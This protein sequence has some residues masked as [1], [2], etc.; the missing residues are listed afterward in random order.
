MQKELSVAF[1]WHFHQPNYQTQP[2]GIRLMPWARLHAIKDYLDMVLILDKFPNIKLNF[3]IGA[4]LIDAIE[5]YSKEG[6]DIH[7]KLA[8]TPVEELTDDDKLY[9]LNYFFDAN[10]ETLISKNPRYN[11]LYI[12][13]YS[14]AEIGIENFS[15]EEYSDIMMLFNLVWFDPSWKEVYPELKKFEKKGRNYTLKDRQDLINLNRKI[16]KQIIPTFKKYQDDKRI[17]IITSPYNH[18][19]APILINPNDLKTPALKYAMPDCKI[20]LMIDIKEQIKLAIE[21]I[22]KTFGRKPKGFWPSEHC[23]SQ[24]TLDVVANLGFEW[25][26]SDE[27]VLSNSLKKEFIR[28]FRG[29]YE[30]PYDVCSLYLYK[31]KREKEINLVFR[32]S[33]IPNLI[34][35]EYAHH[36]STLCA[37]DLFDR[38]KT[39]Y[40]K[41]KNSPDKKHLF[42]IAMDGENNWDSYEQDGAIFLERIYS[43]INNDKAIKTVLIS[44]YIEKN[45][46]TEKLLKKVTSGSWVNQ[47]FQ[48]WIAEPTKNLAWKYLVQTRNDLKEAENSGRLSK[49]QIKNAKDEI[50]IAEGSDWFWWYGEPNNSGQDHIFD[51]MFR[52]HLKNVYNII[53][54]PIPSYLEMPLISFMGKPLKNPKRNIT[55]L[56]N[57]MVKDND[58]WL[59]AGCI[60][61]PD[62]PVI[63]ENKLIDRIYF[64]TDKDNLY[65]RFDINKYLMS[66]KE[67]FKEYFSIY[68]YIKTYN[69]EESLASPTRTTNK[70]DSLLPVLLDGYNHEVKFALTS[71]RK[72]PLQYSRAVKDGLW[73]L[74]WGHH[75][76]YEHKEIFEVC[77][78]FEDL[79]I[80]RNEN[81]DFFVITGCSG[82]TEEIYPKDIPLSLTRP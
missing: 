20:A 50:Y 34:N 4:E 49:E 77:I 66:R 3:S 75:I 54:K 26:I 55:P 43:L 33:I 63:Q 58:E 15:L 57:G 46:K 65:M 31:T 67:S 82:V 13:R 19:I 80:E 11:E 32:D 35:F 5:D 16:I 48:L 70:K 64:G 24:K 23:I 10:Y 60:D 72:Y 68:V 81:F 45:K 29:C 59:S 74:H 56:I 27:S 30:D 28:D 21:K 7:S 38:I 14:N 61:I 22:E 79:N 25:A 12:K 47:E 53:E 8:V 52:E 76:K 39:V 37:N 36:N 41:L 51:F 18:P 71:N 42:T 69:S 1:V 2:N 9:I 40:D 73:E 62:G 6:H 17:E 78:P 44:D